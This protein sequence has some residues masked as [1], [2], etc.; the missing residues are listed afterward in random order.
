MGNQE[1]KERRNN[2][3]DYFKNKV[4]IEVEFVSKWPDSADKV[5]RE[6]KE[7]ASV[8]ASKNRILLNSIRKNT[9]ET[10]S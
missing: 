3:M 7:A 1:M 2:K 5:L 8:W 9:V 10:V 6:M 4:C